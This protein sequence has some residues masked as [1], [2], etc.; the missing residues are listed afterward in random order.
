MVTHSKF[1]QKPFYLINYTKIQNNNER[2]DQMR[3]FDALDIEKE[4]SSVIFLHDR[5]TIT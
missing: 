4:Y 1:I 5:Q 3:K 2:G